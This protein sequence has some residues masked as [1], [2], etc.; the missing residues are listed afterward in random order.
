M[1]SFKSNGII[2]LR[3]ASQSA[4]KYTLDFSHELNIEI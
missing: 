4:K 1:E 3:A 2:D